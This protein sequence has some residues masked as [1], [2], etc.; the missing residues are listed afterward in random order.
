[1]FKIIPEKGIL[2]S[3]INLNLHHHTV[4]PQ[5]D[6]LR[7]KEK[8]TPVAYEYRDFEYEYGKKNEVRYIRSEILE[9]NNKFKMIPRKDQ[10]ETK[11]F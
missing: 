6:R 5:T 4:V 3:F 10:Y 2:S 8:N 1:M 7:L 11:D 9:T